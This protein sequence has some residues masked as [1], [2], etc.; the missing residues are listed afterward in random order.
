MFT[1]YPNSQICIVRDLAQTLK[2]KFLNTF[3]W[4]SSES[5]VINRHNKCLSK[6]FNAAGSSLYPLLDTELLKLDVGFHHMLL[7]TKKR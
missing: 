4:T 5:V 7:L 2:T 6:K 1:D 3:C